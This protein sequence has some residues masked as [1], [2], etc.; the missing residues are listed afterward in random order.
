MGLYFTITQLSVMHVQIGD[1]L[2]VGDQESDCDDDDRRKLISHYANDKYLSKWEVAKEEE[3]I[4]EETEKLDEKEPSI[5]NS[6]LCVWRYIRVVHVVVGF[7]TQ[8]WQ[9]YGGNIYFNAVRCQSMRINST[10]YGKLKKDFTKRWKSKSCTPLNRKDGYQTQLVS[11][12][13]SDM[14]IAIPS[15]SNLGKKSNLSLSNYLKAVPT[16]GSQ[17]RDSLTSPRSNLMPRISY[18]K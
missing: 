14:D 5:E 18:T 10:K 15:S 16:R 6:E 17:G 8:L 11:S 12:A 3:E 13:K 9:G 7:S 2:S 1:G 4:E